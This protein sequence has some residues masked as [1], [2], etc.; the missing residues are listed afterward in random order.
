MPKCQEK[1]CTVKSAI[2]NY[3]GKKEECIVVIIKR[4]EMINIIS[5]ICLGCDSQPNF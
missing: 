4:W 2:F 3:E 5:P 1:G